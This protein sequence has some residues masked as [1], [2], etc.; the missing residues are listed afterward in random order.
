M[1][2]PLAS[3][4]YAGTW[5]DNLFPAVLVERAVARGEVQLADTGALVANTSPHTGRCAKDKYVVEHPASRDQIDWGDVNHP[6]AP[7]HY[8]ALK[9]RIVAHLANRPELFTQDAVAAADPIHR[10]AIRLVTENAWHALFFHWLLRRDR[11]EPTPNV[12][13]LHAPS[14]RLT[15]GQD[16]VHGDVAIALNLE[17]GEIL[18]AGTQYA[19]EV[20]KSVFSFLNAWLPMRGVFPMHCSANIGPDGD[21]AILFGL[22]GTGKTTLSADPERRLIGDDEHGWSDD[23]VFNFEGGCYAKCIRLSPTGEPLIWNAI[24][25][26][27]IVENT[28]LDPRTRHI[29]FASEAITENTRV[30][31]P[32]EFIPGAEPSGR[33][34]PPRSILFLTC[35]AYGVLPP[36]S[37]L[38]T[39][40][41][42]YHFLSG[43]TAKIAGT[44]AG[45]KAPQATF[46]AC[47]GAPFMTLRPARYARMLREKL[48][49]FKTPVWLVN[50]G[51][52]GGLFGVGRRIALDATRALVHAA[53]SGKLNEADFRPDPVFGVHIPKSCPGVP[54]ALLE[55]K[56]SWNDPDA[57]DRQAEMLAKRFRDNYAKF[58]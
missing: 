7:E 48:D 19:G 39:E 55:P 4:S 54:D 18:I 45:I 17:A 46:S 36:L 16:G 8:A 44:E 3:L 10:L 35:D 15:P 56:R 43:Y 5:R 41:A 42:I 28:P 33:G 11:T 47:F 22:S 6:L 38:T 52:T 1:T 13:I 23:G 12:T 20:K 27:S 30:A 29:D 24:R 31:Y 34:G 21:T 32:L 37:K 14:L 40:Q 49:R 50:T 51:W 57:Y 2:S 25:F 9:T 26:G 53:I 58:E